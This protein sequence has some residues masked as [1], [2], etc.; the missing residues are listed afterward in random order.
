MESRE[1]EVQEI[2]YQPF[3]VPIEDSMISQP[4]GNTLLQITEGLDQE[5]EFCSCKSHDSSLQYPSLDELQ[6]NF[7]SPPADKILQQFADALDKNSNVLQLPTSDELKKIYLRP[8]ARKE[9]CGTEVSTMKNRELEVQEIWYQP[10]VLPIQQ[11]IEGLDQ[12]V[13]FCSCKS[14]DSLLQYP[15]PDELQEN[16]KSL[17]ADKILQQFADAPDTNSDILQL[18]TLDELEKIFESPLADEILQQFADAPDEGVG[19]EQHDMMSFS[20]PCST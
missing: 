2:W 8:S 18:P 20:P 16:F 14:H 1:L 13:E 7:E 9:L 4:A 6:K 11:I 19:V 10:F 5:V 12:E 3:V 15:F 17:P